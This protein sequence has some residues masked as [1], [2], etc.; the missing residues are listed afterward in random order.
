MVNEKGAPGK[1]QELLDVPGKII[2]LGIP[3]LKEYKDTDLEKHFSKFGRITE[4]NII[5]DRKKGIPRGFAFITYENPK[6]SKVAI[7]AMEGVDLKGEQKIHC[8]EAQV[9]FKEAKRQSGEIISR[10]G[11]G[12]GR[13]GPSVRRPSGRGSAVRGSSGR[14]GGLRGR[15]AERGGPLTRGSTRG[16]PRGRGG[17]TRGMERGRLG[18]IPPLL[19]I[20]ARDPFEYIDPYSQDLGYD[21]EEYTEAGLFEEPAYERS[22][23]F[24]ERPYG[25]Q[26]RGRGERGGA[27][28]RGVVPMH[29]YGREE[30]AYEEYGTEDLGY[31]REGNGLRLMGAGRGSSRG[32][33][34]GFGGLLPTPA[35]QAE[36]E[37]YDER[38]EQYDYPGQRQTEYNAPVEQR[39]QRDPYASQFVEQQDYEADYYQEAPSLRGRG[40]SMRREALNGRGRGATSRVQGEVARRRP[41]EGPDYYAPQALRGRASQ[42]EDIDQAAR[43]SSGGLSG[44]IDRAAR[45]STGG[46]SGGVDRAVRFPSG[47]L[48]GGYG[49]D[50]YAERGRAPPNKDAYA[51][52]QATLLPEPRE[53]GPPSRRPLGKQ[54]LAY[55]DQYDESYAEHSAYSTE[56]FS[57]AVG[58]DRRQAPQSRLRE[59]PTAREGF[60][61]ASRPGMRGSAPVSRPTRRAAPIDSQYYDEYRSMG[62]S[63]QGGARRMEPERTR[64]PDYSQYNEEET[65]LYA[66]YPSAQVQGIGR[67]RPA[68]SY[69]ES[70]GA[71]GLPSGRDFDEGRQRMGQ[72]DF[73]GGAPSKRDRLDFSGMERRRDYY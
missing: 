27:R 15:G 65:E 68:E 61:G 72:R 29:R 22:L 16:V 5:R 57:E 31:S 59:G 11:R 13:G 4:T 32:V 26:L 1:K 50:Q 58:V 2:V 62:A 6:D 34:S 20:D 36:E 46:P 35:E 7:K 49:T 71:R 10:G 67:K 17:A 70:V 3:K 30:A 8:E 43:F 37:Y 14:G 28:G 56:R 40:G 23:A 55:A 69:P 64:Q 51:R 53:M 24:S 41:G 25:S 54:P 18:R 39:P 52:S 9:G 73:Q 12:G 66:S 42:R 19:E 38:I 60:S 21:E 48:S 44:G 45:L 33:R 47:N 63:V